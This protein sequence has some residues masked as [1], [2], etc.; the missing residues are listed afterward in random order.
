MVA[1]SFEN[2]QSFTFQ[3]GAQVFQDRCADRSFGV[4][5]AVQ[6][7]VG[8]VGRREKFLGDVLLAA[9]QHVQDGRAAFHDALERAAISSQ[10]YHQQWRFEG[11]LRYPGNGGGAKGFGVAGCEDIH[12]VGQEPQD[13]LLNFGIHNDECILLQRTNQESHYLARAAKLAGSIF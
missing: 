6:R 7:S 5:L 1:V 13:F 12:A 10:R 3:V 9:V 2:F 11:R 8:F 4:W